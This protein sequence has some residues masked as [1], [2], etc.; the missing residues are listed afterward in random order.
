MRAIV[1]ALGLTASAGAWAQAPGAYAPPRL[2]NGHPDLQGVWG[3]SLPIAT[4]LETNPALGDKLVVS[5][6][7]AQAL[8]DAFLANVRRNQ[9][10]Q[11]DIPDHVDLAVV[12]GEHRTRLIVE[13]AN[14][15]IPYS[16][17]ARKAAGDWAA[18]FVRVKNGPAWDNPESLALSDRCISL[19]GRPP[20]HPSLARQIVQ[21]PGYIVIYLEGYNESRIVRMTGVHQPN[22]V[23][24]RLGDSVGRWEGDVL[25]V[26]TTAF[27]LDE[28]LY[29]S[30][31]PQH[32]PPF[33]VGPDSR[34]IE[35]FSRVSAEE[36]SYT[37]TIEDPE[38][39]EGRWR[40][41]YALNRASDQRVWES[42]CHE[43][44]YGVANTLAGVRRT[45]L[46]RPRPVQ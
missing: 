24:T 2:A 39:Y 14:G 22:A 7:E 36:L 8:G 45:K 41:E 3:N 21:S 34:V 20:M 46:S 13:P 25:V 31:A 30:M 12:R 44:N 42:A 16:A 40:G 5:P 33:M 37:F 18:E 27:R 43:G 17:A 6:T 38:I 35:R 15:R 23:R 1:F 28:P 32:N 10:L 9:P 29:V 4:P 26:E 19:G 11:V